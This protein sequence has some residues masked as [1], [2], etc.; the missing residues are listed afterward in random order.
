MSRELDTSVAVEVMDNTV[1]WIMRTK[2]GSCIICK[3]YA[4]YDECLTACEAHRPDP[5]HGE[6][7]PHIF[8]PHY[9]TSIA[10]AWLV[11]EKLYDTPGPNGDH[12]GFALE[13][14]SGSAVAVFALGEP[15]E[16]RGEAPTAPEAICLA[17]LEAVRAKP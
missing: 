10:D 2:D 13:A 5:D 16:G 7:E 14:H 8:A 6:W 3:P 11:V 17:A 4:T 1:E 12:Y 9:S 15:W